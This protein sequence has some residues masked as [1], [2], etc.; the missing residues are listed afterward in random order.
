M[1]TLTSSISAQSLRQPFDSTLPLTEVTLP[2]RSPCTMTDDEISDMIGTFNRYGFVILDCESSERENLLAL[3]PL[4]GNA[5]PHKRADA[6][7]VVPINAFKPVAGHIDS[8]HEA[9]LPHTDGAFSDAPERIITLQCVR[10]SQE[11]GLSTLSSAKA[12]YRHIVERYGDVAP[13]TH[14]DALTIERTTQKSTAAVFKPEDDGWSIKFRMNDGA[15]TATPAPAAADMY[16]SLARFLTDP[17]N[18][19]LFPL[20]PG[21]ILI[22]DN[23]AVTHGRTR[24]PPDQRRNMRRLNFD[25]CGA[26]EREFVFGFGED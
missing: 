23:T 3:K 6:D 2:V 4:L 5:A 18:V 19:L 25:G 13:L 11:G 1:L 12:A 9:H 17:D 24:Y 14:A 20:E 15:A 26:L 7:G 22:G 16:G 8:S 21:Q 10:P